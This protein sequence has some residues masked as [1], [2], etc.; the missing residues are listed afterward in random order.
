[1]ADPIRFCFDYLSP[2]AYLA[3]TQVRA[4]AARVGREVQP[5]PVLLAAL[6]EANGSRGP[7]EIPRKRAYVWKDVLRL[8]R[9]LGQPIALPA[10]HPFNPLPA[11]RATAAVDDAAARWKLVDALYRATWVEALRV[12]HAEV[13]ARVADGVNLDGARL[14]EESGRTEVKARLRAFGDETLAAGGFGVPTMI[15]DGELFWGLDSLPHLER[16]VRGEDP[17]T[18][19]DVDGWA[20]LQ[21]SATRRY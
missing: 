15:V 21:P 9:G 8:A 2:Y 6:L 17:I 20:T 7:A 10:T 12:D 1:M 16:F 14:V 13:V 19:D 4:V 18:A 3:A 11:L 5:V